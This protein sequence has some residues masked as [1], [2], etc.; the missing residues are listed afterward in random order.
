MV[1]NVRQKPRSKRAPYLV[2]TCL[3]DIT[4]C[5]RMLP[6]HDVSL[7]DGHSLVQNLTL[8]LIGVAIAS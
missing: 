8:S 7:G 6:L 2:S 4:L 5:L 1:K 3:H